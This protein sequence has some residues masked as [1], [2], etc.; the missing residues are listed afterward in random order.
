MTCCSCWT[1]QPASSDMSPR[2]DPGVETIHAAKT[3]PE[4]ERSCHVRLSDR[5]VRPFH[6]LNK[7]TYSRPFCD[8][9]Q[10]LG[11]GRGCGDRNC[12]ISS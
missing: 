2:S 3:R 5:A 1:G 11:L 12:S 6:R 7:A 8:A 9:P 4:A 10:H